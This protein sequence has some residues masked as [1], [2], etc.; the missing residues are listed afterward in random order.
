[1]QVFHHVEQFLSTP[2]L[3]SKERSYFFTGA[4]N[5]GSLECDKPS[6]P[7]WEPCLFIRGSQIGLK[8]HSATEFMKQFQDINDNAC[9]K[10]HWKHV[11]I[12]CCLWIVRSVVGKTSMA[13]SVSLHNFLSAKYKKSH[14]F[15]SSNSIKIILSIS[16]ILF[17]EIP[18]NSLNII[19]LQEVESQSLIFGKSTVLRP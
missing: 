10:I 8:P 17:W 3:Y 2:S 1:M 19:I 13:L 15:Q 7:F 18:S 6:C 4:I 12:L 5:F 16:L 9:V 11:D 14:R